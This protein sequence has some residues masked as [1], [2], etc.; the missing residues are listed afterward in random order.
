MLNLPPDEVA[1]GTHPPGTAWLVDF[2]RL[3]EGGIAY[4]WRSFREPVAN[5]HIHEPVRFWSLDGIDEGVLASL[6][7]RRFGALRGAEAP[8]GRSGSPGSRRSWRRLW[9]T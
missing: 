4:W 1:W 3:D 5:H 9:S 6:R 8:R 2:L 7:E